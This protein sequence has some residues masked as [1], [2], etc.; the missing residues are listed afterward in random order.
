MNFHDLEPIL[1]MFSLKMHHKNLH[2]NRGYH[3]D[4]EVN[5]RVAAET[6]GH[7]LCHIDGWKEFESWLANEAMKATLNRHLDTNPILKLTSVAVKLQ[8]IIQSLPNLFQSYLKTKSDDWKENLRWKGEYRSESWVS[9]H[10]LRQTTKR[11]I[12]LSKKIEKKSQ[13]Y[14]DRVSLW[15]TLKQEE[16]TTQFAPCDPA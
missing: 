4:F 10:D 7:K 6:V 15:W 3:I 16:E 11:N 8:K 9:E 2:K 13:R 1:V 12:L 5:F 14:C